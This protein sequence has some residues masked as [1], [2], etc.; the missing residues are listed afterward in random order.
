MNAET[1]EAD[2]LAAIAAT[3]T[4]GELSAVSVRYLGRKSELKQALRQVRDRETGMTLNA[5]R[6]RIERAVEERAEALD[7]DALERTLAE[8]V[9]DVTLPGDAPPDLTCEAPGVC[10]GVCSDDLT[11]TCAIDDDC[12]PNGFCGGGRLLRLNADL[13]TGFVTFGELQLVGSGIEVFDTGRLTLVDIFRGNP[14]TPVIGTNVITSI[15][16]GCVLDPIPAQDVLP[17]PTYLWSAKRGK[18]TLG[19]EGPD[20]SDD[21]IALKGEFV[22]PDAVADFAAA[23]LSILLNVEDGLVASLTV[24]AGAM[25]ANSKGTK[26]SLK[27]KTG[28]NA[29]ITA[30]SLRI[31]GKGMGKLKLKVQD[32]DLGNADTSEHRV[33]VQVVSGAY[34]YTDSRY[35]GYDDG[36]LTALE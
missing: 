2:A 24:P 18:V 19:K 27:D 13:S 1:L 10:Q 29:G 15:T 16:L 6:E 8:D 14:E 22:V 31:N 21:K 23:D 17:A 25:K 35:W 33:D 9:L 32:V 12:L 30:A 36:T 4:P 34:D 28:A 20:A 3:R 5:I 11:K 26:Y 7:R